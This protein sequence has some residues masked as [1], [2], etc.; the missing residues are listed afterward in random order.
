LIKNWKISIRFA[1]GPHHLR[2][3]VAGDRKNFARSALQY[4]CVAVAAW[5]EKGFDLAIISGTTRQFRLYSLG[6]VPFA[7][8]LHGEAQFQRMYVDAG[9]SKHAREF[10]RSCRRVRS[11]G[12]VNSSGPVTSTRGAPAFEQAR[13]RI[14]RTFHKILGAEAPLCELVRPKRGIAPWL[15]TLA[16]TSSAAS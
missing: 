3:S 16:T 12:A 10:L 2:N 15:R 11:T 14:A 5:N 1:R 8:S 4:S 6:F 9:N 13:N 7:P